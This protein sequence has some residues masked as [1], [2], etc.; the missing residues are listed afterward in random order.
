MG[1]G[2]GGSGPGG[3]CVEV[4]RVG[5]VRGVGG[6]GRGGGCGQS[7]VRV[8]AKNSRCFFCLFPDP[9]S[10]LL[11]LFSGFSWTWF[12]RF[13][14]FATRGSATKEM[15][16]TCNSG[17]FLVMRLGPKTSGCVMSV[18]VKT[19]ESGC[20]V[21]NCASSRREAVSGSPGVPRF[22]EKN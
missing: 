17:S 9:Y 19:T 16:T 20:E 10:K 5:A 8:G 14:N 1:G 6:G 4:V 21:S 7:M 15:C 22:N 11:S 18:N 2:S 3:V 12:G 13:T